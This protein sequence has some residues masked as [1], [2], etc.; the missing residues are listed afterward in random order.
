LLPLKN[1]EEEDDG[2]M[3][4]QHGKLKVNWENR[5][6]LNTDDIKHHSFMEVADWDKR[7]VVKNV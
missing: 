5:H 1:E 2:E 3:Y 6:L 7:G 4:D